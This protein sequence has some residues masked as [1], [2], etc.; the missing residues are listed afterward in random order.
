MSSKIQLVLKRLI[1]ILLSLI[2]IALLTVPFAIIALAIKLDSKG[3]VIFRQLRAG[4]NGEP[5]TLYKLRTMEVD[6]KDGFV[7]ENDPRVTRLGRFLRMTSLDEIPQLWNILKGEMSLVGP[8]PDRVFRAERYD[9]RVLC[10]LTVLP[11]IMGWAQLHDGRRLSWKERYELDLG[12]VD[13]WSLWFDLKIM[14][15]SLL[16]GN[17]VQREGETKNGRTE[18]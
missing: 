7:K 9:E 15:F 14:A 5:F 8:R 18:K 12:Y 3:A 2:G 11:G 13:N 16:R 17:M 6:A 1:D 10:R 4:K